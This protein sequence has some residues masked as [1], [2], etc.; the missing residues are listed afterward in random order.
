MLA[1]HSHMWHKIGVALEVRGDVLGGLSHSNDDDMD[2]LCKVLQS[3]KETLSSPVTWENII[4]VLNSRIVNLRAVAK[5]IQDTLSQ[6]KY[7][8]KYIGQAD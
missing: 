7:Y 4:D 6:P 3:W 2:K 8:N 1:D 5:R